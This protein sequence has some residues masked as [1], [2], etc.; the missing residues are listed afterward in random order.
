MNLSP[1]PPYYI[2]DRN[3]EP[4]LGYTDVLLAKEALDDAGVG[5][6]LVRTVD[7]VVL[8]RKYGM[9]LSKALS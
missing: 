1:M 7:G 4:L 3:G 2:R 6:E 8:A 5:C 9:V